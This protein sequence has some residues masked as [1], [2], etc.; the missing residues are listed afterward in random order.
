MYVLSQI[1]KVRTKRN[2][3]TS[4]VRFFFT[5]LASRYIFLYKFADNSTDKLVVIDV[6]YFVEFELTTNTC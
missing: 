4:D 5:A 6:R 2:V 3:S 1:L